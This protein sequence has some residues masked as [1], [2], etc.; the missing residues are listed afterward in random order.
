MN[1]LI[2]MNLSPDWVKVFENNNIKAVHWSAIGEPTAPDKQI[3]SWAKE[4]GSIVFT[5]DLDFG[6]ILA[7]TNADGPS[8]IQVRTQDVSPQHLSEIVLKTLKQY[9]Q[10]LERG[11]LIA[12]DEIKSRVRI[13]S[14]NR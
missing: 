4:N 11:A 5:H 10:Q 8:V 6:A 14:V 7:S 3:M 12:V 1:I 9:S 2:D 13:L